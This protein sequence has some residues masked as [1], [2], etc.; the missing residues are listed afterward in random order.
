MFGDAAAA[1]GGA[2]V[3]VGGVVLTV[4]LVSLVFIVSVFLSFW[5]TTVDFLLLR[6]FLVV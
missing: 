1:G 4:L 5:V 2:I 6:L 3:I